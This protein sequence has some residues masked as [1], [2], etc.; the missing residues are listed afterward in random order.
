MTQLELGV[1]SGRKKCLFC[2]IVARESTSYIV[3]EDETS[4]AFLDNRP[5][6]PGHCLLVP[7][8][9]HETLMELP[10]ELVE[11]LF[12]NAQLLATAIEKALEADG[13]FVAMN[14]RVSQSIPHLHI[15][16]VP[17]RRRDGLKGF[18]W[19]KNPYRDE[20]VIQETQRRIIVVVQQ[21]V[22][23]TRT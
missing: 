4:L 23:I 14:N 18:F 2:L 21:L 9:H 17:R 8:N 11:P 1:G 13:I 22:H 10:K 3:F 12:S 5:L 7:K 6:F 20:Q 19:P 16:I 15:H